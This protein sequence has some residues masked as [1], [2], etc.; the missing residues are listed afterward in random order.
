MVRGVI[1]PATRSGIAAAVIL[2]L[3][4]AVGEAIAVTQVIGGGTRI[5]LVALP[6]GDTLA[7]K[8]AS[9]YQGAAS[10]PRDHRRLLY[11]AAILLVIGLLTNL[12]A[13]VIVRRFD[14]LRGAR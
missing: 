14:P 2:G 9:S 11:L 3:G 12:L 7:S 10:R 8:I 5:R 1:L 4:R 13:Q 6:A